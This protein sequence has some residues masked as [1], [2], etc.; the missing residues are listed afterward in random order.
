MKNNVFMTDI[1]STNDFLSFS[2]F[3]KDSFLF[4][5]IKTKKIKIIKFWSKTKLSKT[6]GIV[7]KEKEK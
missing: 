4:F 7:T 6:K 3:F 2:L 5:N 1:L